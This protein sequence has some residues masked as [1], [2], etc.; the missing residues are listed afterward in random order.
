M[1]GRSA[2]SLNARVPRRW[3]LSCVNGGGTAAARPWQPFPASGAC[4]SLNWAASAPPR[5]HPA[6]AGAAGGMIRRFGSLNPYA[7]GKTGTDMY[8]H[9]ADEVEAQRPLAPDPYDGTY[10]RPQG[11]PDP[12]SISREQFHQFMYGK[13][14]RFS[15]ELK[16]AVMGCTLAGFGIGI[17]W[18]TVYIMR[19]DDF[20]WVEEERKRIQEAKQRIQARIDKA[21]SVGTSAA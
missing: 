11:A 1:H 14:Q 17:T 8:V 9:P 4:L 10:Q 18:L 19:P 3:I 6:A 20:E 2:V 7:K 12:R 5:A 13:P 15:K 16:V 21:D